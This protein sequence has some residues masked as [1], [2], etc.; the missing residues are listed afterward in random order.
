M[1]P[2]SLRFSTHSW[3]HGSRWTA[4]ASCSRVSVLARDRLR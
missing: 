1:R 4:L 3:H 2:A